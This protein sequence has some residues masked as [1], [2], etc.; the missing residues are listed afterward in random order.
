MDITLTRRGLIRTAALGAAAVAGS[1]AAAKA[2]QAASDVAWDAEYDVVVLGLG[3]TGANA[4]VAAYEEGARVLVCEKAPEGQ[5][6]ANTKASGQNIMA[7]DDAEGM[8]AYL[9]QLMNQYGNYDPD[10]LQTFCEELTHNFTWLTE[11]LGADPSVVCPEED[12]GEVKSNNGVKEWLYFENLMGSGRSGYA[13]R[14]AEFPEIEESIHSLDLLATGGMFD[15]GYYN[16]CI[17]AVEAREGD[18]LTVWKGCPG[19]D[20]ILDESGA[21]IGAVVERDGQELRVKANGGVVLATGGFE[22][23][24]EMI[25]DFTQM[26][27]VALQAGTMNTGDG[28]KMAMRAGADLWHMSSTAG[29][30]WGYQRPG[31]TTCSALYSTPKGVY[32][33]G[34]GARFMAEGTHARHGRIKIGGRWIMTPMPLPVYAIVDSAQIGNKLISSFSEG[35][36]DEIASGEV[37]SADS[38]EEL[39]QKIRDLGD[40]PEFNLNGELDEAL[41]KYNAHCHAN[42]GAGETDDFGRVCTVPVETAPFYAVRLVPTMYNTM[43]GPRRNKFAQVV[44]HEGMPIP[45]LF[46]GGELGSIFPDM[47]N[48]GGNLGE[49]MVF[50]RLAG[51]NAALRAQGAFEGAT[52]P[53]RT[54]YE[55]AALEGEQSE[56]GIS[57]AVADMQLVDGTYEGVGTG[58]GGAITL[59][60]TVENGQ[61]VACDIVSESETESIGHLALPDYCAQIVETQDASAVDISTGASNTLRGFQAAVASALEQAQA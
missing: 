6:P 32:V 2:D 41:A 24:R 55:T 3:G 35:N 10:V 43:G 44:N 16:T 33:G 11:T 13:L 39:S 46:A 56:D 58:F 1:G 25:A 51:R 14:W 29:W 8:Y 34:N 27:Y 52:E 22:A 42:D 23:N 21:V 5:E 7:T 9:S 40:A 28:I 19:R 50:G 37:V 54:V 20:L 60:V 36:A 18:S 12:P 61:I 17:A 47:Y 59:S 49:T 45:G 31:L 53:C 57:T 30:L 48:G 15:A 4:A 38:I 26:P